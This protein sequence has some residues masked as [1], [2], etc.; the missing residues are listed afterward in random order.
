MLHNNGLKE[1]VYFQQPTVFF[2]KFTM[3]Y[4]NYTYKAASV[5]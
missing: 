4:E 5:V 3:L 2:V 1:N